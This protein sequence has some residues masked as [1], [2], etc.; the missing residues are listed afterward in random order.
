MIILLGGQKGGCGKTTITTNLS[1]Y[2]QTNNKDV[3]ILDSDVQASSSFWCSLR[4]RNVNVKRISN[5]QKYGV[6]VRNEIITL[7]DKYT[8][9]VI[10]T[11]GRDSVE[12]RAAMVV[13][14]I[15]IFPLK[16][17]QYDMWTIKYNLDLF[18][19]VKTINS[20]LKLFFLLN[21]V[22]VNPAMKDAQEACEY[23][24][25]IIEGEKIQDVYLVNNVIRDRI[26][27]K[28]SALKGQSIFEYEPLDTK[29]ILELEVVFSEILQEVNQ[30]KS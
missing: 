7:K 19:E 23:I 8:D 18:E 29:A 12:L 5:V 3:L 22:S 21:G 1:S 4:D 11:G 27:Y 16:P 15:A 14:D 10:D 2:L 20:N 25:E 28:R 30:K 6:S 9:I 24:K 17:S 26:V 13:S